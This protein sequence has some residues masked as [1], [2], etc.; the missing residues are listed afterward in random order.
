[1]S[2][3]S[4]KNNIIAF[5]QPC[6]L[7]LADLAMVLNEPQLWLKERITQVTPTAPIGI[8]I[9]HT[10]S[11]YTKLSNYIKHPFLEIDNNL[12]ENAIRPTVIGR[13]NYMFAG[14]HDGASRSA[15]MYSFLGSGKMNNINPQ[16]WLADVLLKIS[17]I[18]QSELYTLLPNYWKKS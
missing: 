7:G 15:M 6:D 4:L 5:L 13:K 1:L 10:L 18:K 3:S 8:A 2:A 11:R 12:V 14:S 9:A 16:E 17:D